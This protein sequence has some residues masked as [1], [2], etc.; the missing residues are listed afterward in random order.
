MRLVAP[1]YAEARAQFL[2]AAR[3]RGAAL[4]A[5]PLEGHAE[6]VTDVAR[7]G[8]AGA[9]RLLVILSGIHG[10]EGLAGSA[11]QCDTLGRLEALFAAHGGMP[12]DFALLLVHAINP[13]GMAHMRRQNAANIDLNR[14][15]RDWSRPPPARPVYAELHPLILPEEMNEATDAAFLARAM[16]LLAEHGEAWLQAR[17]TEGQYERPDGHYWGGDGPAPET[18]ALH[19]ILAYHLAGAREALLVDCHTGMG[20]WGD[21]L[22]IAGTAAGT[23]EGRWLAGAF[24]PQRIHFLASGGEA[25]GGRWPETEGKMTSAIAAAHPD[26]AVRGF[27]LEFGTHD[28]TTVFL[29]ERREH[30]AWARLGADHPERLAAARDLLRLMV[31]DDPLWQERLTDGARAA[32]ADGLRALV[33][34]G[35]PR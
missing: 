27:S 16:E 18:L 12:E 26:V 1:T 15:F 14:N 25:H 29:A 34:E 32:I 30:W 33:G 5:C 23:E 7:V 35:G 2:A 13:W 6:L 8:P 9:G 11:I 28:G 31:P 21:W 22:V 4:E 20:A 17:L 24:P 3:A 10:N 19:A